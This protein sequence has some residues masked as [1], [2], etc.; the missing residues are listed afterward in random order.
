MKEPRSCKDRWL[1]DLVERAGT[2]RAAAA[3]ANKNVGTSWAL[4]AQGTEY[5]RRLQ[6][7]M[8]A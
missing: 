4:I 3:L 2:R 6:L 5:Q 8:A 7:E 1:K